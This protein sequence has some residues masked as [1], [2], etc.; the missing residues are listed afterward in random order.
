MCCTAVATSCWSPQS[1]DREARCHQGAS[2]GVTDLVWLSGAEAGALEPAL[3][4][5]PALLSPSTGV[6]DSHAFMLALRGG[7]GRHGAMI[8]LKTPVPSGRTTERGIA[9]ETGGSGPMQIKAGE[10]SWGC[11]RP[12]PFLTA[13]WRLHSRIYDGLAKSGAMRSR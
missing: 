9:I 10:A 3:A 13:V 8:A 2:N 12:S 1:G 7:A 6:I 11:N 4:A 5:E